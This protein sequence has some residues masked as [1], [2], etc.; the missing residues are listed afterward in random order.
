[1]SHGRQAQLRGRGDKGRRSRSHHPADIMSAPPTVTSR[2]G[3]SAD[4]HF[5]SP[6][7]LRAFAVG[8]PSIG[9]PQQHRLAERAST[10]C[11]S[12]DA[13]CRRDGLNP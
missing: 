8:R 7:Q 1:M 3:A 13:S 10:G 11:A 2:A 6:R 9:V 4:P 5:Y 12:G